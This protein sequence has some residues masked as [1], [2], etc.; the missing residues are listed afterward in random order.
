[1]VLAQTVA[2]GLVTGCEIALL[3]LGLS[4]IY[5]T[6]N[7]IN[8][9]QGELAMFIAFITATFAALLTGTVWLGLL[10]GLFVALLLGGVVQWALI[11]PMQTAPVLSAVLITIG[12][13]QAL[14]GV[15]EIVWGSRPRPFPFSAG[16][17]NSNLL[18][19]GLNAESLLIVGVTCLILIAFYFM[20]NKTSFGLRMRATSQNAT[21]ARLMG[22][23]SLRVSLIV[24][25]IASLLG[26]VC[27]IFAAPTTGLYPTMMDAFLL[28]AFA[29]AILGGFD[30]PIGVV[31]GSLIVGVGRNVVATYVTT[32]FVD[33]IVFGFIILILYIR[34]TGLFGSRELTKV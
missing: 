17:H 6:S 2:I 8:F 4:I 3:A 34:P 20:L 10:L 14:R 31:L 16:R 29:G 11:R 1:M 26:A 19:V 23:S 33:V 30:S 12:L 18:G 9:A 7:M 15:A 32:D 27:A 5:V 21:V 13:F 25:S 28:N 22:I 24:W